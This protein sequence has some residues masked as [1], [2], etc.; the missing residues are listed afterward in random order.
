MVKAHLDNIQITPNYTDSKPSDL[1]IRFDYD[2]SELKKHQKKPEGVASVA[3]ID[4][5]G[6]EIKTGISFLPA[7]KGKWSWLDDRR[8]RFVPETDWPAGTKYTLVFDPIIF[9]K[10]A[11]LSETVYTLSTPKLSADFSQIEFYQDPQDI[12]VRRVVTTL[13]FSHPI[14]KESLEKN[15]SM[16]MRAVMKNSRTQ[17]KSYRFNVTYDK[18]FREAYIQS[19]PVSLPQQT[20]YMNV[21][22]I[23]GVKSTLGG[24]SSKESVETK[25]TIPDIYSFLK[26]DSRAQIVR[27]EKNDPEQMFFLEF[28]DN[29]NKKELLGK[30]AIYLLPYKGQKYGKNYW[31]S[32]REVTNN[33]LNNSEKIEYVTIANKNKDSK[34]YSFKVDV[35]EGRY[36]YIKIEKGLTSVNKFIHASFYDSVLRVPNYPKEVD[37]AGEGSVLTYSGDH[38]LSILTRGVSGLKYSIGRLLEG[39]LYHLISQ[40]AGDITNPNFTHWKFGE[41]NIASFSTHIVQLSPQHPK[42]ANYSSINLSQYLTKENNRYGLFFVDIQGYDHSTDRVI[43]Q[44]KDKRLILITDLGIIVKNNADNSHHLFVQSITTGKPVAEAN[45]ELLGKNGVAVFSGKTDSSGHVAIPS[46]TLLNKEKTP[47][48]YVV[49]SAGDLSFIPFDRRSRQIHLSKFDIGGVQ[50]GHYNKDSLNAFLFSDRGIYRPGEEVNIGMIV[51]NFDLSNVENIPLEL[52]IRGPRNKEIKVKKFKLAKMGFSDFQYLTEATTDTG[53][54]KVSLHLVRSDNAKKH[55]RGRLIGSVH[56][57]VEEFQP[58]TM[59]IESKLLGVVKKGW[60]TQ[61]K[62][63]TRVKLNNLFGTPAQDRK[64][65]ASVHIQ[66]HNFRFKEYEDYTF[67]D[68]YF[69][70]DAKP[71]SLHTSLGDKK[72][73]ADGVAEFELDLAKFKQG[74]YSLTLKVEGFDQAGGRSVTTA[75]TALISP[76]E[77][78]V[79]YKGDG[80]LEYIHANSKRAIEFIA[81]DKTLNKKEST[82]L[83]LKL[84]K[85]QRIS[86]LVKQHNGTFKYQ[87]IK[88]ENEV[89]AEIINVNISGYQYSIDT[90]TPGDFALEIIDAQDRTLSRVHFSVVGFANL[91]GK[92]DKNAELQV[93]L[94]KND[95]FPDEVIEMSIKA[96]YAGAGLITIETDKVHTHKWFETTQE[97]TVQHIRIPKNLEGTGY[98][99]VTFLRDISS[100][101]VFTSPLSYAVKPF[102]IDKSKRRVDITLENKAIVRPGKTMDISFSTSKPARIAIFAVDEGILQVARYKTPDP[103]GH[104]LKKRALNVDTL[105]ILDL[106][107]PDFDIVKELSASGGG[108]ARQR[109]L[110]KNLNPFSRKTDKPA[111]FWSGIYNANASNKKISFDVPNTFSGELRIMAV[112]VG[113]EAIGTADSSTIVRGPFVISPNVLTQAAPGDEFLVTVGVANIIEGSGKGAK[114]NLAVSSSKHLEI[115]G[116]STTELFIDE[117]SEGKFTFKVKAKNKLGAAQLTFTAKHKEEDAS[118]TAS[119]SIRPATTYYST[120][121]S[122]FNKAG[123]IELAS[124]RSLYQDLAQQSV[125]ASSSPLVIVDGLNSYL[126]TYPHGC[127]EQVVSKVFPL[128]GLMSHPAYGT[129]VKKVQEY[130]S[131]LVDKLRER[132]VSDGGFVFWPHQTRSA[133]YPSIYVMHF[134]LEAQEQGFPVPADMIQRG[135]DYLKFYVTT[136]STS[137]S[138]ARDR[139]NA[140]YLLTRLGEVTTNH[141]VDLEEYLKKAHQDDWQQDILSTYMASTYKLLQKD[142]EAVSLLQGYKLNRKGNEHRE[143]N[144][145]HSALAVDAQYIYLLSKHFETQASALE[146]D[147]I[148]QLTERIFK[149]EYNT[150]SSAY[151]ILALGAYSKLVLSNNFNEHIVFN[152]LLDNDKKQKLTADFSPFLKA[153]YDVAATKVDVIGKTPLF[154]LNAQSGFNKTLPTTATREG[155]EILRSFV[156]EQ[157]NEVTQF[158]QGQELTVKL[159]IR[160]LE[161]QSLTN[162]AVIDL[163][164]GGF[165]IIRSSVARTAY[166]WRA[167]YIDIREDRVVYYGS[168]D[169]TMRELTYKVKL[170]SAGEFTIPPSYAESMYDRSIRAISVA[171]KFTVTP[172]Q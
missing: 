85:I 158:E 117:G 46:T 101:E 131:H 15:L 130:F 165:E 94:N 29:I 111:V 118:R 93:K 60:N 161:G 138:A 142:T 80:D 63:T 87:T 120:F 140:I 36:L 157:D 76:L 141:L 115:L 75:N 136:S 166:N 54:Y 168:F 129:H 123:K 65:K 146:G 108:M 18:N 44:V 33:V 47:T 3:R 144:D 68:P 110:A 125:A 116:A 155:L 150:I 1:N 86:T 132:Q 43:H 133:A 113:E 82:H 148:L 26:V 160:A 5:I 99:N 6:K 49:K 88:K 52:V 156:D 104:F 159:K 143:L 79:G 30:M 28:T 2:F 70:K 39:Q 55:R 95:Y 151:S 34:L 14:E 57:N 98:V 81:I 119:L 167:D 73:D 139:A 153:S 32:P 62:I 169:S 53:Q 121:T 124:Q 164:P 162:I 12:S 13:K 171:G 17:A 56:F 77:I 84:K 50:T 105:Q 145:F 58:D 102:S 40:T 61:E 103:L 89:S 122:G 126:E 100:K 163:L 109:A 78:L 25:V 7:K 106:I 19:E 152:A 112:A 22:L 172:S 127:T 27:N 38:E 11:V 59:K 69:N 8:M 66:P 4:L 83:T 74:T 20:N 45:V 51:K 64:V 96:P 23:K 135:K 71:L 21:S 16:T 114:V 92:M 37:I 42:D 9:V 91:T 170:T 149:G 128:V 154:Y 72:S 90:E 24:E 134:L 97:S 35:P 147:N 107:L 10:E 137:L 31:K 67:T 41:Q 48:V